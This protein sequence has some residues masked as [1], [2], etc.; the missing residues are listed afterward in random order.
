MTKTADKDPVVE[1]DH[2]NYEYKTKSTVVHAIKDIDL[3]INQG[4]FFCLV[5][6]SGCGKSTLLKTIAGY[7]EPTS[8]ESRMENEKIIGPHWKRGVVFQSPTLYPWL[9]VRKNIEY[10]PYIRKK[11]KEEIKNISNY[12]LDQIE[13]NDFA[14]HYPFELSGGMKQRVSLARVL[15]NKPKLI[16]MDEPFSALDAITRLKMQDFLRALWKKNNQTILLITHD[17]EEALL[18]GTKVAVMSRNPG[19]IQ[20]IFSVPYSEKVLSDKN[21]CIEEDNEFMKQKY[22]I[23][24]AIS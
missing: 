21:Y 13:L 10:G 5:G 7:I 17:I 24:K 12:Y 1:L 18:L 19:T 23:L 6:P 22:A 20:S 4:D 9:T 15:A 2:V 14:D 11:T 8:G 3:T 16:L